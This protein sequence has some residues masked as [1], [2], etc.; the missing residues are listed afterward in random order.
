[1]DVHNHG[2]VIPEQLQV[3]LFDPFRRGT[4]DSRTKTTDGLGLGLYISRAIALAHGGEIEVR[5]NP[6]EGTTFTVRLR[7]SSE[8][9]P[10]PVP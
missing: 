3:R 7:S 10:T 4:R 9:R 2:P 1:M 6:D 5:S 8:A